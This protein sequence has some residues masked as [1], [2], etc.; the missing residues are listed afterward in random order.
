MHMLFGLEHVGPSYRTMCGILIEYVFALGEIALAGV[1]FLVRQW[2]Y[3]QVISAAPALLC[4]LYLWWVPETIR[5]LLT[6]GKT[7][8]ALKVV[9]RVE[10]INGVCISAAVKNKEG[11]E[12]TDYDEKH[13]RREKMTKG[14]GRMSLWVLLHSPSLLI[15]T[16][17]LCYAW[18][19][20]VEGTEDDEKHQRRE[21]MTKGDGRMSLWV[22]LHSPS[23]LIRTINLCY[24]WFVCSLDYYGLSMNAAL[25]G[26]DLF[27]NFALI[28]AIEIPAYSLAWL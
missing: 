16:I 13:Q 5:W 20:G 24:A 2:R 6:K 27:L 18:S 11:V 26:G 8:E 15:R 4:L 19:E 22:L 10:R 17:N 9:E 7:L 14:D 21:K 3:L 1:A 12:G 23:L 28:S 25:L